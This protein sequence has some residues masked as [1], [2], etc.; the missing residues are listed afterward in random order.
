MFEG[1]L[2][3]VGLLVPL[4]LYEVEGSSR[5]CSHTTYSL[6][7]DSTTIYFNCST[8]DRCCQTFCC[9]TSSSSSTSIDSYVWF[10]VIGLALAVLLVIFVVCALKICCQCRKDAS[11]I[12]TRRNC[13]SG[14][15]PDIAVTSNYYP[16]SLQEHSLGTRA[17]L[18]PRYVDIIEPA[19]TYDEAL[20]MYHIEPNELTTHHNHTQTQD[21]TMISQDNP[22]F[23]PC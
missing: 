4:V 13:T 7:G 2:I 22:V 9:S 17:D 6:N 3:F 5:I 12:D 18:P 10:I 23:N 8:N 11:R 15:W 1:H 14:N 16:P 21:D 19:P 20:I